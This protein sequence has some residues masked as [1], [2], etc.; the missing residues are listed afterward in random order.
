MIPCS[1]PDYY[2]VHPVLLTRNH[3]AMILITSVVGLSEIQ[4]SIAEFERHEEPVRPFVL[5]SQEQLIP[6]SSLIIVQFQIA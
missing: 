6:P 5:R 1:G 4:L 3:N 2:G